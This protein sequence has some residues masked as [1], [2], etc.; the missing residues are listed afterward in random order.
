MATAID[1]KGDLIAGT[2]ADAFS[3]LAIGAN[4]ATLVA[5]STE[6]TGMKW[7]GV[8]T[9]YT[10]S[11]LNITVGNGTV[12]ARYRK[13]GKTVQVFWRL[14]WGST[15]SCAAYPIV[16][17]PATP[18]YTAYIAGNTMMW[19]VGVA[20]YLGLAYVDG[21]NGLLF[22]GAYTGGNW[23]LDGVVQATVPATWV[24]G[25]IWTMTATYEVA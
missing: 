8:W 5:D 19:D 7:E 4:G 6:T 21:G 3:R 23:L 22:M 2:G 15:T 13:V 18:A 11:Y 12:I 25:D 20:Q 16:G 1:A 14:T 24:A 17:Y 9:N 10:P